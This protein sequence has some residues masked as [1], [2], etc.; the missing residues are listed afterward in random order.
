MSDDNKPNNDQPGMNVASLRRSATGFTLERD[1]LHDNPVKQFEDWFGYACET[2]PMDPNAVSI[3][4]V[5]EHGRPSSRT[6]PLRNG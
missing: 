1:D 2:V 5:D 4:T 3:A 6:P